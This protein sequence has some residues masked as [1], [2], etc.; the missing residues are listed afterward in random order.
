MVPETTAATQILPRPWDTRSV[1]NGAR[2]IRSVVTEANGRVTKSEA[3]VVTVAN[4]DIAITCDPALLP[5][6]SVNRL[7][8]GPT[9]TVVVNGTPA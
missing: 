9:V 6:V 2:S 5:A 1:A 4:P 8:A 7:V 3:V